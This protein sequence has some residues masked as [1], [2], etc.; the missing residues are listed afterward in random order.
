MTKTY[1]T[2]FHLKMVLFLVFVLLTQSVSAAIANFRWIHYRAD[3]PLFDVD[4]GDD[5]VPAFVDVDDDGDFDLFIGESGGTIKFYENIGNAN[6][7]NFENK[8]D[9]ANP[10]NNVNVG[11][12]SNPTFVDIDKDGD[13]DAFIGNGIGTIRFYENMGTANQPNFIEQ[14]E[15]N[16]PLNGIR[17]G[18][19]SAPRFVDIDN[20]GDVDAFIGENAGTIQY[21]QNTGTADHPNFI[22]QTG[23]ANPFGEKSLKYP[24]TPAFVDI[25]DDRDFDVVIALGGLAPYISELQGY[26]NTFKFYKN[27]GTASHPN[28]LEQVLRSNPLNIGG[29]LLEG[30]SITFVDIDNDGDPDAFAGEGRLRTSTSPES[31]TITYIKNTSIVSEALPA[32]GKYNQVQAVILKCLRCVKIHYTLDGTEP[33]M[34]SMEFKESITI[35]ANTTTT[36]KY[37]IVDTL[38]NP[39][40]V[41]TETYYIDTT[42]PTIA[43]N[44]PKEGSHLESITTIQGVANDSEYSV[45]LE[46]IEIQVTN[47]NVY[48]TKDNSF[49]TTDKPWLEATGTN[50]WSYNTRR[51]SSF[52]PGIYTITAR[53][54]DKA[55]NISE[56]FVQVQMNP[57]ATGLTLKLSGPTILQNEAITVSGKLTRYPSSLDS[58]LSDLEILL[59]ITAPDG[60]HQPPFS[61]KTN[62]AGEYQLKDISVF[63]LAGTYTLQTTFKGTELLAETSSNSVELLVGTSAGYAILVQGK[64]KDE[65]LQKAYNKTLK[66]IYQRLMKRGF[67]AENIRYFN[68]NVNQDDVNVYSIP[69]KLAIQDSIENWATTRINGSPAPFYLI[70]IDH[71]NHEYFYLH[72]ESITADELNTWLDTLENGLISDASKKEPR[73]FILGTCYSGSFINKVSKSGRVIITSAKADEL[74]HAGLKEFDDIPE[75]EFFIKVLFEQ[76][77]QG[78][79]FE[80]SFESATQ[81]TEEH[82]LIRGK[83]HPL[84]DDDGNGNG[85]SKLLEVGSG[86]GQRVRQLYLG[87]NTNFVPI[88]IEAMTET[89]YLQH[90]ESSAL[91]W[92]STNNNDPNQVKGRVQIHSPNPADTVVTQQ[93]ETAQ[94]EFDLPTLDLEFNDV[95]SRFE[96]IYEAFN[97][98]GQYTIFYSVGDS[99]GNVSQERSIVYKNK[100]DNQPPK[101]FSLLLPEKN[102]TPQTTLVLDWENTTDPDG[103]SITYHFIIGKD[104]ELQTI[105]YQEEG[106]IYSGI[107]ID[108]QTPVFDKTTGE[109]RQGLENQTTYYWRVEAVDSFGGRTFSEI[110]SFFTND[111]SL[112]PGAYTMDVIGI[113][114]ESVNNATLTIIPIHQPEKATTVHGENG[115]F[116]FQ[117]IGD[118]KIKINAPDF[119]ETI[120]ETVPPNI[121]E[122]EIALQPPATFSFKDE[123]LRIPVIFV[124]GLG[125]FNATL[126]ADMGSN[127][128]MLKLENAEP[129]IYS[130]LNEATF[131]SET[132]IVSLPLVEII[133]MSGTTTARFQ[134]ELLSEPLGKFRLN[135]VKPLD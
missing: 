81:Q 133:D 59:T 17:V 92:F 10:L 111:T 60:S 29:A 68:Y 117:L 104:N 128:I 100:S 7:P 48:L 91:L 132:G 62:Q 30:N 122:L 20:D 55:N 120:L 37:L 73:F 45:E 40:E 96:A 42:L 32:S 9:S 14:T 101:P 65:Q 67:I 35:Q 53:A 28:F 125:Y 102:A 33:T 94:I 115:R 56:D 66:R 12:Y 76:L 93:G 6:E 54:Y 1:F 64:H 39:S 50:E 21:Y 16:N 25:D 44:F 2:F 80:K 63:N 105:V 70:M 86:D 88:D 41:T 82:P 124:P 26:G 99:S 18:L 71:G 4:V 84:L 131:N 79:T 126:K 15:G 3:H 5:S 87:V 135:E 116:Q 8:I 74:S 109:V 110:S 31:G 52:P 90:T 107:T 118:S 98:P 72:P 22:A 95:N 34:A 106:L 49:T 51:V 69:N 103:D 97:E 38:G 27:T 47:G 78:N 57:A 83:Q 85:S 127:P 123:Q 121:T 46:R 112:P 134:I 89:L 11:G 108:N 24:T 61:I 130:T 58:D 19:N 13:S 23:S 113:L 75:G 114:G 36:L 119:Q 77:E 129:V 43:I